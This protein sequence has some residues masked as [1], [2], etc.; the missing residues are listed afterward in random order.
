MKLYVAELNQPL[1]FDPSKVKAT[2]I[3]DIELRPKVF[4]FGLD[5]KQMQSYP[6]LQK[7]ILMK[8]IDGYHL[9]FDHP[10]AVVANGFTLD[11]NSALTLTG[12]SVDVPFVYFKKMGSGKR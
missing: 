7:P 1:S 2:F 5:A 12:S 8:K 3:N 6:S 11:L 4:K 9:F 10:S